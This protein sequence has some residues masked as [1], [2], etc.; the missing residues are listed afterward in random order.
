MNLIFNKID[1]SF[2]KK[3]ENEPS[4]VNFDR[5][6]LLFEKFIDTIAKKGININAPVYPESEEKI[7]P[8]FDKKTPVEVETVTDVEKLEEAEAVEELEEVDETI[9]ATEF[10]KTNKDGQVEEIE[11]ALAVEDVEELEEVNEAAQEEKNDK[12]EEL[13]ELEEVETIPDFEETKKEEAIEKPKKEFDEEIEDIINL[14]EKFDDADQAKEVQGSEELE[15]IQENEIENLD[16]SIPRVPKEF[17]ELKIDKNDDL[18]KEIKELENNIKD[19]DK[20]LYNIYK[21]SNAA[22]LIYLEKGKNKFK[23]NKKIFWRL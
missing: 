21:K 3:L 19:Y 2:E 15:S 22:S 6:E 18:A 12:A 20:I 10:E 13:E 23:F 16:E 11:E 5:I 9:P 8:V 17:Y 4:K 14:K 7:K 1:E